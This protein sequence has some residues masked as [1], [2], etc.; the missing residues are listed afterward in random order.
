MK[1]LMNWKINFNLSGKKRALPVIPLL[2]IFCCLCSFWYYSVDRGL[3]QIGLLPTLTASPTVTNTPLPASTSTERPTRTAGPTFT[4]QPTSVYL[5]ETSF[6]TTEP[7]ETIPP[8]ETKSGVVIVSVNKQAEYVDITNQTDQAVDLTGWRLVSERGN[9]S[10]SLS[11]ILESKTSLRIYAMSGSDGFNCGFGS[12]I[13]NN[14][15][16]DPAV[17]YNAQGL[18]VSRYP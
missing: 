4:P 13:W 16:S 8:T 10:C 2:I 15:Q 18:E 5:T 11:G 3:R 14:S 7:T 6:P 9:Q 12:D 17:L 1:K